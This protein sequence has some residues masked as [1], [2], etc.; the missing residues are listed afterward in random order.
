[1]LNKL[2]SRIE[3]PRTSN[4]RKYVKELIRDEEHN[5]EWKT[6]EG[7]DSRLVNTE[8]WKSPKQN[9]KREKIFFCK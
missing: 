7:T 6:L 9:S 8:A 1:M 2:E 5:T 4:N 3:E